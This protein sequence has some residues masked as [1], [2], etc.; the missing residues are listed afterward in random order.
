MGPII[1][2]NKRQEHADRQ[3]HCSGGHGRQLGTVSLCSPLPSSHVSASPDL[4]SSVLRELALEVSQ[5]LH[6]S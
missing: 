5:C 4:L 6:D 3:L 2:G 1:R